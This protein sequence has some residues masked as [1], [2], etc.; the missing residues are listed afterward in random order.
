MEDKPPLSVPFRLTI[1]KDLGIKFTKD[2]MILEPPQGAVISVKKPGSVVVGLLKEIREKGATLRHLLYDLTAKGQ[3]AALREFY[4]YF[5]LFD[6]KGWIC[7]W[8]M[9]SDQTPISALIPF[10]EEFEWG[11]KNIDPDQIMVLSRFA[12][13]RNIEGQMVLETP[14]GPGKIILYD[15]ACSLVL[16]GLAAPSTL[17][18]LKDKVP[19]FSLEMIE[20]FLN[21]LFS[22]RAVMVRERGEDAL[23]GHAPSLAQW[24]FHDLLFHTRSRKKRQDKPFGTTFPFLN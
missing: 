17:N 1:Q 9:G 5:N 14:L 23:D 7:R 8:I 19:S 21:Q 3:M 2:R 6:Q 16:H 10:S 20:G 12:H 22:I 11:D 15:P 13:I 24:E 18:Q 4:H